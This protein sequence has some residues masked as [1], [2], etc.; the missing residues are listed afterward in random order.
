MKMENLFYFV[1]HP[2]KLSYSSI[3]FCFIEKD[4]KTTDE[5]FYALD[6]QFKFCVFGWNWDALKDALCGFD[7]EKK[8][9]I[10]IMHEAINMNNS[11]F[12]NYLLCLM[13]AALVW[14][15]HSN[16]HRFFPIFSVEDREKIMKILYTDEPQ[17]WFK[18]FCENLGLKK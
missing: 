11:V 8:R 2:Q 17:E 10:V 7:N 3:A 16:K 4:V 9:N 12:Y 18:V 15:K 1:Q 5:L 13:S 6:N 14:K